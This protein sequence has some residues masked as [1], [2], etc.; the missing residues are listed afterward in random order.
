M[1]IETLKWLP[2]TGWASGFCYTHLVLGIGKNS[3]IEEPLSPGYL[4]TIRCKE[5]LA[6]GIFKQ[7]QRTAGFHERTDKDPT[8]LKQV[9]ICLFPK[10]LRTVNMYNNTK[11]DFFISTDMH[12]NR[13]FDFD[14]RGYE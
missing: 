4:K 3:K 9:A 2:N 14:D 8:V 1:V 7:V 6:L 12:Q 11:F 13:V 5:Q 10:K